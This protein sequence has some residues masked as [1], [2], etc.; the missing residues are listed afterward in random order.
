MTAALHSISTEATAIATTAS[1]TTASAATA[2]AASTATA[3]TAATWVWVCESQVLKFVFA[4]FLQC[5]FQT[6]SFVVLVFTLARA[7]VPQYSMNYFRRA[8]MIDIGCPAVWHCCIRSFD[9]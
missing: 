1:A 4:Y 8:V 3:A 7:E 6:A 9:R 5:H 2:S